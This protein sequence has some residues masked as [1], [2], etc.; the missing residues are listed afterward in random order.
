MNRTPIEITCPWCWETI[1]I[2]VE[3]ALAAQDY[4][5]DCAVCCRPIRIRVESAGGGQPLV[6]AERE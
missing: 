2:L 5:E 3:P 4:S 6:R 1:E